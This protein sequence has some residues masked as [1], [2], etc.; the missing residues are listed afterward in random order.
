[1]PSIITWE[2]DGP[3]WRRL[4]AVRELLGTMGPRG[5]AL[6]NAIHSIQ[7]GSLAAADA[8]IEAASTPHDEDVETAIEAAM[9]MQGIT[10]P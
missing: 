1:M 5:E 4:K 8:Y 6:R 10:Q 7:D 9:L 2:Y 3:E